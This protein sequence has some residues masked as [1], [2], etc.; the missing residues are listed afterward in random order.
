MSN[1][2]MYLI[3]YLKLVLVKKYKILYHRWLESYH[4]IDGEFDE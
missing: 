2:K 1:E 4:E 3:N